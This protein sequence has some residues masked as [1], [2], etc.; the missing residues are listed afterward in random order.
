MLLPILRSNQAFGTKITEINNQTLQCLERCL[1]EN[2]TQHNPFVKIPLPTTQCEAILRAL[3]ERGELTDIEAGSTGIRLCQLHDRVVISFETESLN[4]LNFSLRKVQRTLI[5]NWIIKN[6]QEFFS[7]ETLNQFLLLIMAELEAD[8]EKFEQYPQ[9]YGEVVLY[10]LDDPQKAVDRGLKVKAVRH[11]IK[12]SD[13]YLEKN[14]DQAIRWAIRTSPDF[15]NFTDTA[16]RLVE[17]QDPKDGSES[18]MCADLYIVLNPWSYARTTLFASTKH[19]FRHADTCSIELIAKTAEITIGYSI[20]GVK[21]TLTNAAS[22]IIESPE[23]KYGSETGMSA[24]FHIVLNYDHY[25]A[26]TVI[27]AGTYIFEKIND[28]PRMFSGKAALAFI[29]KNIDFFTESNKNQR[30]FVRFFKDHNI[31]DSL[32]D[33]STKLMAALCSDTTQYL[34]QIGGS[35]T[36]T[37]TILKCWEKNLFE[38]AILCDEE[39]S[40]ARCILG[41]MKHK[42]LTHWNFHNKGD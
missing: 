34:I 39:N 33:Y 30:G 5:N 38:A 36:Y 20:E 14:L 6:R 10:L 8:P 25:T 31:M 32:E 23:T 22:C 37:L 9:F 41:N 1:E 27:S 2:F 7:P 40:I 11:C 16:K 15:N 35:T 18:T 21:M 28:Y 17:S 29:K 26:P 24:A 19:I 12:Q 3:I 13:C 4:L 42:A